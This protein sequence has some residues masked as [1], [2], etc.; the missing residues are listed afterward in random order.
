[1][2][3][4]KDD[5]SVEP[6]VLYLEEADTDELTVTGR[7]PTGR[8]IHDERGNAL[9]KW[10]G[11]TSSADTETTSG[12]LKYI[13]PMDLAVEGQVEGSGSSSRSPPKIRDAGG[14]YDPYNQDVA[15]SKKTGVPGKGGRGKG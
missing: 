7:L 3:N 14:G 13:D 15:R 10:R 5:N 9:W 1:M 6:E 4:P 8:I 11:D 12:V 2:K